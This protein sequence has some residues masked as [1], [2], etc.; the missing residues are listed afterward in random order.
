MFVSDVDVSCVYMK[1]CV[2]PCRFHSSGEIH[3]HWVQLKARPVPVRSFHSDQSQPGQ[4]D[5]QDQQD[6][7]FRGRASLFW[8]QISRGNASLLLREVKVQDEGRY[9]CVTNSSAANSHSFINLMVDGRRNTNC[10]RNQRRLQI[11]TFPFLSQ[12]QSLS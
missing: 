5:Q 3:I 1:S 10:C 12:L 11:L 8:D 4:Q 6:Q 2:L 7:S 9:E